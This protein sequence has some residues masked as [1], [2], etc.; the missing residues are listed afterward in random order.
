VLWVSVLALAAASSGVLLDEIAGTPVEKLTPPD[1]ENLPMVLDVHEAIPPT[2]SER[3]RGAWLGVELRDITAE[4]AQKLKLAGTYGAMVQEVSKDSPAA[5]SGI[6]NGDLILSFDGERVRSVAELRRMLRETPPGRTVS[7][8]V[9]RNGQI[10]NLSAELEARKGPFGFEITPP[11][12]ALPHLEIPDFNIHMFTPPVRLGISGDAL[13]P[14]LAEYF[15]VKSGKGVLISEV[16]SGSAAEKAGLKAGDIIIKAEDTE[17]GS[18]SDLRKALAPNPDKSWTV[19]LTI[20]RDRR[21]QQVSVTLKPT[22]HRPLTGTA[23]LRCL[24]IGPEELSRLQAEIQSHAGELRQAEEELRKQGKQW[25]EGELGARAAE[26]Q[27]AAREIKKQ[28]GQL[29]REIRRALEERERELKR[30]HEEAP[31]RDS[32]RVGQEV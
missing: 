30:L 25:G 20:V 12:V 8:Q 2:F 4:D 10:Q 18:L 5:R 29:D 13:T 19:K 16:E 26:M 28:A 1:D 9:S 23:R 21:E 3:D 31:Q 24:G 11:M 27:Q 7:I 22:G 32:R 14:Q 6:R 17:V 15:G